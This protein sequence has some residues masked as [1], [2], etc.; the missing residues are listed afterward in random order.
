MDASTV[1]MT[2]AI[3]EPTVDPVVEEEV[4][5]VEAPE[6]EAATEGGEAEGTEPQDIPKG[7]QKLTA[8]ERIQQEIER[9]KELE[10]KF[11]MQEQK[12]RQLEQNFQQ[13]KAPDF[14][15]ITPQVRAQLNQTMAILDQA[16]VEAEL[17]GDYLRAVQIREKV[18]E[19]VRSF[20][21]N[22]RLK[23][24]AI[25]KQQQQT[26]SSRMVSAVNER[27]EFFRAS[28][29][30]PADQWQAVSSWF[31]SQC[32]SDPVLGTAFREAAEF[33]G[34][35]AAV[36]FAARYVNENY[37]KQAEAAKIQKEQAK[38]TTPGGAS[39]GGVDSTISTWD[40]LMKLPSAKIN[41]FQRNNPK[42]FTEL[43]NAATV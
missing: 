15:E 32:Q 2:G 10:Q 27:A 20:K 7:P 23:Q 28:N 21:E 8:A 29:N 39:S 34:P 6:G 18:E 22:D 17:D 26:Q 31:T 36:Q 13:Q 35:M 1:E 40:Q 30:I 19:I 4:S 3:A 24:I 33:Q 11:T 43:R 14:I 42:A 9:R 38:A 25:Q 41:E 5:T 37:T 12:I 16:R